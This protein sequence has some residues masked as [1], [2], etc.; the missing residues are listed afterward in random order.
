M[1]VYVDVVIEVQVTLGLTTGFRFSFSNHAPS[2]NLLTRLIGLLICGLIVFQE[3]W[4]SPGI[5]RLKFSFLDD[6]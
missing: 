6:P 2:Y 4:F 1:L 3:Y 5:S